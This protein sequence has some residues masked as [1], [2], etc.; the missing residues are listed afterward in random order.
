MNYI[1][2]VIVSDI[3]AKL[4]LENCLIDSV[5]NVY[6]REGNEVKRIT[7][8]FDNS[9]SDA[10]PRFKF[11]HKF[12]KKWVKNE[13]FLV[14]LRGDVVREF[15]N[16]EFASVSELLCLQYSGHRDLYGKYLYVGDDI[17]FSEKGFKRKERGTVVCDPYTKSFSIGYS[18]TRESFEF[19]EVEGI[20]KIKFYLEDEVPED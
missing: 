18:G 11:W 16:G 20:R 4:G 19:H 10:H 6:E 3:A 13:R 12:D 2:K 5:G 15:D 9:D 7:N 17:E 1:G 14:N 8:V